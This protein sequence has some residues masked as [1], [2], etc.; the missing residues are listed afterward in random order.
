MTRCASYSG[1]RAW[2]DFLLQV[3]GGRCWRKCSCDQSPRQRVRR[4][5]HRQRLSRLA[6]WYARPDQDRGLTMSTSFGVE[7]SFGQLAVFVQSL[8]Q[9]FNDWTDRHVSQGFAWR[10]GSVSFRS[11]AE[12]GWHQIEIVVADRMGAVHSE[13]VR[14]IEVP[15]Q[16]PEG[17]AMEIGSISAS[18]PLSLPAGAFLLRCEFLKPADSGGERA[19]L[20]FARGEA[21]RFAVVRA[22]AD[23]SVSGDLLTTAQP[24]SD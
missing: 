19:R 7:V 17:G 24:A 21:L 16:V 11:V 6:G 20:T 22:D 5:L 23:L 10:P 12:S 4:S 14:V 15:F 8:R 13:A 3:E 9:P 18:V 1:T 2:S